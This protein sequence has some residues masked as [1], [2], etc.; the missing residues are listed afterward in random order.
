ME[1]L[2]AEAATEAA[3]STGISS[4]IESLSPTSSLAPAA[5]GP[6]SSS[7]APISLP[8]AFSNLNSESP[9]SGVSSTSNSLT[10][11]QSQNS[12]YPANNSSGSSLIPISSQDKS[13]LSGN[14][15]TVPPIQNGAYPPNNST[16]LP[17]ITLTNPQGK[18][19][20]LFSGSRG[21]GFTPP[22]P[23]SD[24]MSSGSVTFGANGARQS[25]TDMASVR[26]MWNS[27]PT[28]TNT[29]SN[30]KQNGFMTGLLMGPRLSFSPTLNI[31]SNDRSQ[32]ADHLAYGNRF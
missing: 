25:S 30:D 23:S 7:T 29:S 19:F 4:A 26:N 18:N 24:P 28:S 6:S 31:N 20:S 32:P 3:S 5:S 2:G 27:T 10:V 11:P 9:A 22:P 16:S 14:S 12:G 13:P 21:D 15:L 8:P 1:V 17:S